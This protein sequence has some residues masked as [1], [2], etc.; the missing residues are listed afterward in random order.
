MLGALRIVVEITDILMEAVPAHIDVAA[1]LRQMESAEGVVAVHD[2]H[3]WTI[4]T[5]MVALSAHV[6]V[7]DD[8]V[9]DNDRILTDVKAAL[10]R[11]FGIDHTTLQIE[12]AGYAHVDDVHT[13]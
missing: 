2:L 13:H 6:V 12:S 9:G 3:V 7:R 1:V 11:T 8:C 5:S 10:R 4:S